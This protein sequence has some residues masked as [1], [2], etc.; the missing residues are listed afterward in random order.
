MAALGL[1]SLAALSAAPAQAAEPTSWIVGTNSGASAASA[2]PGARV[3][4]GLRVVDAGRISR[5]RLQDLPGVRFVEPNRRF[6]A[7]S[8]AAPSDPLFRAQWALHSARVPGAWKTTVGGDV[9]VAVL[10]SGID[11]S[12]GELA[13]NLWTNRAEIPG[14]GADDDGNGYVDDVNGADVVNHDGTPADGYG[15]G[16]EVASIIGARGN[17]GVG[18]SGV[19]WHVR[20]MP[21][22]VLHDD[23]WGTTLTLIEGLQYALAHGARVINMSVNGPDRSQALDDAIRAAE[24]QGALIVTSAGNDGQNRDRVASYPASVASPAVLTVASTTRSGALASDSGYGNSVDIAAPGE[25][26]LT[27][28]LGGGYG[29]GSGTSF[30]AAY[31]S[32]A[33]ALL[34]SERPGASGVQLRKAL[35]ASARRGGSVDSSIS[36]G[37]LDVTAA[38]GKLTGQATPAARKKTSR[39]KARRSCAASARR[40]GRGAARRLSGAARRARGKRAKACAQRVARARRHRSAEGRGR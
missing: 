31:V 27:A 37:R 38:I 19:D 39:K 4:P 21:V 32:G 24:A 1:L 15:H 25:D 9:S 11:F 13:S 2:V 3:A 10:D 30:A 14:N 8:V 34:A 29:T 7:S 26:V 40:S 6:S 22:K 16:T 12:N 5:S 17:D 20:L 36:G 35:V 28:G 23:G 18:M 33:A